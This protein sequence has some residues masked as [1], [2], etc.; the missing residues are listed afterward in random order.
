MMPNARLREVWAAHDG[1][2]MGTEGDNFFVVSA[3]AQ[4]A[5]AAER[6]DSGTAS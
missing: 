6:Q 1:T 2:K 4:A 3:T 5:V